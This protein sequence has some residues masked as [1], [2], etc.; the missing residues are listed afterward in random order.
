MDKVKSKKVVR[1]WPFKIYSELNYR[2]KER[3]TNFPKMLE[4]PQNFW[5]QEDDI[6]QV[7]D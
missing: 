5:H 7:P 3:C 1:V 6:E 4:S 2:H